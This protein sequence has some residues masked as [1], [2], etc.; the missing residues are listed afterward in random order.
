MAF[1]D[2][3]EMLAATI[4]AYILRIPIAHIAGGEKTFG[5]LD[6]GF[7][8]SITKLSNLHFPTKKNYQKIINQLGENKNTIF[9]FIIEEILDN[10]YFS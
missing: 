3:F 2:R 5:S 4:S 10:I 1:G 7:R 8:H 9:N 6:E